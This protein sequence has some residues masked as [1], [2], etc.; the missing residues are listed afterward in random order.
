MDNFKS[1]MRSLVQLAMSDHS[2]SDIEKMLIFSIGKAHMMPEEE[3]EEL[4]TENINQKGN[5]EITFSALSFDEKFEYL[6]NIIQLMKIDSKVFLSEI[7]YCE[8]LAEKLGFD[9]KVVKKISARIYSDPGITA[10][11]ESLKKEA[12]KFEK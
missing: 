1:H 11:R 6:Y 4:I 12:K 5:V 8:Q 2:F 3:I 10:D 7:K 9:K